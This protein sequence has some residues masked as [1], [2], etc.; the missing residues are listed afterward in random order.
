MLTTDIIVAGAAD[1]VRWDPG[2]GGACPSMSGMFRWR[3]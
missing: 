2:T 1:A 3:R